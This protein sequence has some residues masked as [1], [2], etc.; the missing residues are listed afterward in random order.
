MALQHSFGLTVA[1]ST[2][3]GMLVLIGAALLAAAATTAAAAA[4]PA[5]TAFGLSA[6]ALPRAGDAWGTNIHWTTPQPGEAAQLA[7][8]FKIARM[9]FSWAS[10]EKA[11]GVYSF[12]EY[13]GLVATLAAVGVRPYLILDYWNPLYDNGTTCVSDA[14]FAAYGAFGA[15]AMAHFAASPNIIWEST[16]EPNGMGKAPPAVLARLC[17]AV[18]AAG[19]SGAFL[20]PTTAGVDITYLPQAAQVGVGVCV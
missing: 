6:R 8:A 12:A 3:H 13:E 4:A 16:N 18:R 20:G 15:A 14:C 17:A 2:V 10:V 1:E 9:D 19:G 11:L 7:A 5:T